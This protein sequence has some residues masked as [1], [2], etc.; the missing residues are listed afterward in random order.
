MCKDY[1]ILGILHKYKLC[2][3]PN[4]ALINNCYFSGHF[5]TQKLQT[6]LYLC[7][8]VIGNGERHYPQIGST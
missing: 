7:E 2:H 5:L 3:N 6:C 4:S 8:K 1:C